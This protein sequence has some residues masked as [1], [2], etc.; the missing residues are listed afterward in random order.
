MVG[1]HSLECARADEAFEEI[2]LK[3]LEEIERAR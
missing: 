2:M 3:K 1:F